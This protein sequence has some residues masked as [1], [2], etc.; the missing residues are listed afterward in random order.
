MRKVK[1]VQAL[2]IKITE[3]R[4]MVAGCWLLVAGY[5]LLVTGYWLLVAG[6][7]LNGCDFARV[8]ILTTLNILNKVSNKPTFKSV[9]SI[10]TSSYAV[11]SNQ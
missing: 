9:A 1:S 7:S 10:D 11:T 4:D 2:K 5:W 8:W 3:V 6:Y